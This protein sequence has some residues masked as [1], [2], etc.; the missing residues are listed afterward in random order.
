MSGLKQDKSL[1]LAIGPTIKSVYGFDVGFF[2]V[3]SK[4]QSFL[5]FCMGVL[6]SMLS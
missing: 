5:Y 4:E 3:V 6:L 1:G 2:L